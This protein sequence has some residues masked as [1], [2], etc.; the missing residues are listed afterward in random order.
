M[1]LITSDIGD[2]EMRDGC[3]FGGTR[4]STVKTLWF[5]SQLITGTNNLLRLNPLGYSSLTRSHD[6]I[7][8]S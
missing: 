4:T 5:E 6:E 3:A 1:L 2:N 7:D 8:L